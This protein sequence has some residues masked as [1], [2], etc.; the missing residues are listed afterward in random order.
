VEDFTKYLMQNEE[1]EERKRKRDKRVL[2]KKDALFSSFGFQTPSLATKVNFSV[3]PILL[4]LR[5]FFITFFL[6]IDIRAAP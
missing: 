1:E 4:L 5:C 2:K 6:S 3:R